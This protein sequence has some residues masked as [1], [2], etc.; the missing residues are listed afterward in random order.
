GDKKKARAY[1]DEIARLDPVR[2][3]LALAEYSETMKDSQAVEGCFRR[4]IERDPHAVDARLSLAG[5]LL[6]PWRLK[7]DEAETEPRAALAHA[8]AGAGGWALLARIAA[9]RQAATTLDSVLAAADVRCPD[10]HGPWYQAGRVLLTE[11][12]DLPRA[13]RCFRRYL[14]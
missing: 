2:G 7:L 1:A 8:P 9:K 13:E 10:N 11:G 12:H 3:E 14:E 6:A 5:W 4:A